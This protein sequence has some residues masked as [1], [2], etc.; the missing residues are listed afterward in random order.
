MRHPRRLDPPPDLS[1]ARPSFFLTC[2]D[3]T[4]SALPAHRART[5]D[6]EG[7]QASVTHSSRRVRIAACS[8]RDPPATYEPAPRKA[9]HAGMGRVTTKVAAT[10]R[11]GRTTRAAG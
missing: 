2:A 8:D 4:A 9:D 6:H 3:P 11:S 5:S 10:A 7:R 1:R